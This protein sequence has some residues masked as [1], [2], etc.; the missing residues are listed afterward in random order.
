[1]ELNLLKREDVPDNA[2]TVSPSQM[3][4]WYTCRYKWKLL[5]IDNVGEDQVRIQGAANKGL[6]FHAFMDW[7]YTRCIRFGAM[8]VPNAKGQMRALEAVSAKHGSDP[9][10]YQVF[11]I[12]LAYTEWAS[13]Y[14]DGLPIA[15]EVETFAFTGLHSRDGRPIYLHGFID[16]LIDL[17]GKLILIDHKSHTNNPWT[18]ER[19]FYDHQFMFY[20][21]LLELQGVSV[22]G[23]FV[24][25]VNLFIP[26]D[27]NQFDGQYSGKPPK[28]RFVR[29]PLGPHEIKLQFYLDQFLANIKEM[30]C[31]PEPKYP[32]RLSSDCQYCSMKDH[33]EMDAMGSGAG[34]IA[35]LKIRHNTEDFVLI[36]DL[37]EA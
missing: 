23:A 13:K 8:F 7:Y 29:I 3:A 34:A 19:L 1:M 18:K 9:Q 12:F 4:L 36:D 31:D 33:I 5:K 25:A 22:D 15:S 6:I 2:I 16:L 37:D 21:L 24:N 27:T 11:A 26:K 30:W 20:W 28:R 17:F 35:A 14:E 10:L 32:M